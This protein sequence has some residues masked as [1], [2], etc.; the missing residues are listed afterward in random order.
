M[1]GE[2][3]DFNPLAFVPAGSRQDVA[4]LAADA[5]DHA[6]TAGGGNWGV[7]VYRDG[8]RINV[9]WTEMVTVLA[10]VV[11]LIVSGVDVPQQT[12]SGVKFDEGEDHRGFYPTVP[13][14]VLATVP[15]RSKQRF[16]EIVSALRPALL[17]AI[18]SAARRR[19]GRGVKAGHRQEAVVALSR[20]VGRPLP[21]PAHLA[22]ESGSRFM[23]EQSRTDQEAYPDVDAT[24]VE[25][26]RRLVE[27]LRV[28]RSAALAKAKKATVLSRT[29][30]LACEVCDFD[31]GE[32]YGAV[33]KGFCEVH[34]RRPLSKRRGRSETSLEDLAIVCSNCH[35]VLHL[36]SCTLSVEELRSELLK[37][38][39]RE[40]EPR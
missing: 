23:H 36:S 25:G 12:P 15:L 30:Q 10:D 8:L 38:R 16:R 9:G 37:S 33:A 4:A 20:I 40:V 11:R 27:H 31:F 32:H 3:T 21:R 13:G 28:E 18:E 24:A 5:I 19:V 6:A 2:P 39:S 26:E 29:G 1:D 35:R 17:R 22:Q 34:H 7:T 14:S